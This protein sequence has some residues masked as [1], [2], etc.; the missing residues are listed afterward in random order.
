MNFKLKKRGIKS[1]FETNIDWDGVTANQRFGY[2]DLY[3][4]R[5]SGWVEGDCFEELKIL[6]KNT[7]IPKQSKN[8]FLN[9]IINFTHFDKLRKLVIY[10]RMKVLSKESGFIKVKSAFGGFAIYK[11]EIFLISD[12]KN[13]SEINIFSEHINFHLE[14]NNICLFIN[15]KLINNNFN[16]YNLN[17]LMIIRFGREVYKYF[18]NI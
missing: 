9:F 6:K 1:C 10:D 5:A 4:L 8:K 18:K 17:K 7:K 13:N 12:Y 3:A 14:I 11:P 15:P 16:I 2:Y